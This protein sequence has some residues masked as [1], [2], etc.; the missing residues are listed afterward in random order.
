MAEKKKRKSPVTTSKGHFV[1]RSYEAGAK[2]APCKRYPTC[3]DCEEPD[4]TYK[5]QW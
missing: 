3:F 5:G 2:K 1:W 4:C